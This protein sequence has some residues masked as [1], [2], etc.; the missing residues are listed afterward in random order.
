LDSYTCR[1]C[2]PKTKTRPTPSSGGTESPALFGDPDPSL[3]RTFYTVYMAQCPTDLV[4]DQQGQREWRRALSQHRAETR[5]R[6]RDGSDEEREA[7]Q[8]LRIGN[9]ASAL[10]LGRGAAFSL[11]APLT[12]AYARNFRSY[13]A[14]SIVFGLLQQY[15]LEDF[16]R[17]LADFGARFSPGIARLRKDWLKFRNV[18]W[19]SQL[20]GSS[21]IPQELVSRLRNEQGTE[22][23]FTDLEGDLSTYSEQQHQEALANLQIYGSA[24]VAFGPLATIVGLVGATG[25]LLAIL[26]GASALFALA[27][28]LTV[29]V[30]LKGW[31]P[32]ISAWKGRLRG[33]LGR[34]RGRL[35]GKPPR[36]P[37]ETGATDGPERTN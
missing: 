25:R 36:L 11:E 3:E 6:V 7:R 14:E 32:R 18:L 1:F 33:Y 20:S 29:R 17:R 5:P 37:R 23:L 15:S 31:P 2:R 35:G 13:W 30:Q 22:R 26:L 28:L 12:G 10:V 34:T 19:W 27:V 9:G 8:T 16:Q 4:S 24:I 21:E